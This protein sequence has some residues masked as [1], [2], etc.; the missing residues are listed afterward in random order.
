MLTTL[1]VDNIWNLVR[2][3]KTE[4]PT[5][6][7]WCCMNDGLYTDKEATLV[8]LEQKLGFNSSEQRFDNITEE[9]LKNAAEMFLYINTCPTSQMWKS[10]FTSWLTFYKDIFRTESPSQIILTL[11]RLL[12]VKNQRYKDEHEVL[13]KIFKRTTSL[14]LLKYEAIQRFLPATTKN[15]SSGIEQTLKSFDLEGNN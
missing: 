10:R 6:C 9:A 8:A 7:Q 1:S 11:N 4:L 3:V 5:E 15:A 13:Q 12:K 14:F 2:K